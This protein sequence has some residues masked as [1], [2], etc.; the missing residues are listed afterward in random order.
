M[1]KA[2]LIALIILTASFSLIEEDLLKFL[3]SGHSATYSIIVVRHSSFFVFALSIIP[4]VCTFL[5]GKNRWSGI[6]LFLSWM[7]L[8]LSLR[9]FAVDRSGT[10]P[11]LISGVTF[12]PISKCE[13]TETHRCKVRFAFFLGKKAESIMNL[14]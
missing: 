10:N 9:T 3:I 13:M 7:A 8:I 12:F 5:L 1:K 11:V 4:I 14:K 6:L 2:I